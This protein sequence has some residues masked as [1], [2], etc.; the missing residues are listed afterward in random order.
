MF[1]ASVSFRFVSK[2]KK[3]LIK[4]KS[5]QNDIVINKNVFYINFR[6]VDYV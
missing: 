6:F 3:N 5:K 4:I 1:E 2:I